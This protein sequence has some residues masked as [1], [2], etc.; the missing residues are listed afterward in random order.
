MPQAVWTGQLSFGLVSIPVKLYSAAT[1]K[2]VRF[3]QYDARTGR[4]VR[5]RRVAAASS[6]TVL[7][8]PQD[9]P[10]ESA[11]SHDPIE[12]A[13]APEPGPAPS[14]A[15]YPAPLGAERP[16]RGEAEPATAAEEPE[17]GWDQ[18]VKGFEVE[19][20]RVVTVSPDE[21]M[22]VAPAPSRVLDVE[23]FV[24]LHEIDPV[25]YEKSYYVV[26]Q[27]GPTNERPYWLLYRAMEAASRVAVG[28]FVMRTKEHLA[29]VRPGEDL[30]ILE[31]LFYADEIRD[32]K[33]VWI[34]PAE[35]P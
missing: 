14:P 22:S 21:V 4:R 20:G 30:L 5:Y 17:V 32:T 24:D 25:F 26:P 27:Q 34:P 8:P 19:P 15:P 1:P 2:D 12:Y 11:P 29:V 3:H 33:D 10:A 9:D 18:I 7:A 13:S 28:R 35:D 6:D 23:R 31:T 16:G